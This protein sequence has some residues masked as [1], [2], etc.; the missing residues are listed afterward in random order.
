MS[1]KV[2]QTLKRIVKSSRQRTTG[3]RTSEEQ[4]RRWIADVKHRINT[5]PLLLDVSLYINEVIK[6]EY[7]FIPFR[8]GDYKHKV[9]TVVL[10]PALS[11]Y[12][13][14]TIADCVL[15]QLCYREFHFSKVAVRLGDSLFA[16][17]DDYVEEMIM[18]PVAHHST[19]S[20]E[21][22][23]SY[24]CSK[25]AGYMREYLGM[26]ASNECR[27][28][29]DWLQEKATAVNVN[30]NACDR[31]GKQI[32]NSLLANIDDVYSYSTSQTKVN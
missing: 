20:S 21:I 31:I 7:S 26:Y 23:R 18:Y 2:K 17:C 5:T 19:R 13:D 32:A 9:D 25:A 15:H 8:L 12:C 27:M 28:L 10:S 6:V 11:L 4:T 1:S 22:V 16:D 24:I 14:S 29:N 30:A 3:N